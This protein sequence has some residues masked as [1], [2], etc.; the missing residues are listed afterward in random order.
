[1]RQE[2]QHEKETLIRKKILKNKTV[3][4]IA[5]DLETEVEEILPIYNRVMAAMA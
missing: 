1:M 4:Q 3:E 5:D 2:M